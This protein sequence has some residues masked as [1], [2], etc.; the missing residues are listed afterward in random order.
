[1]GQTSHEQGGRANWVGRWEYGAGICRSEERV[2]WG[3]LDVM[4]LEGHLDVIENQIL[5]EGTGQVRPGDLYEEELCVMR[6]I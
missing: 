2:V 3:H 4:A 1:M 5:R 6:E